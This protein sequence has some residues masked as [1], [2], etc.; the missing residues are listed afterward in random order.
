ME[1]LTIALLILCGVMLGV[2]IW[3]LVKKWT[4]LT[5]EDK[6]NL[7]STGMKLISYVKTAYTNDG[8]IDMDEWK[9][10][11]SYLITIIAYLGGKTETAVKIQS[12]TENLFED[13]TA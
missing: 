13:T 6:D 5:P 11:Y 9:Q 10:I 8:K 4:K 12:G 3:L 1:S 7:F 2:I